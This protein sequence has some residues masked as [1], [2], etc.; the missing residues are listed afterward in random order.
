MIEPTEMFPEVTSKEIPLSIHLNAVF[1]EAGRLI[2]NEMVRLS[3]RLEALNLK[4][5]RPKMDI[6]DQ[7]NEAFQ[8]SEFTDAVSNH[9]EVWVEDYRF[10]DAIEEAVRKL[11]FTVEVR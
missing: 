3:E 2:G 1:G 4:L 11:E 10:I 5:E 9:L 8:S 6:E 7:I